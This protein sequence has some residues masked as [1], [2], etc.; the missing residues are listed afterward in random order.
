MCS[1]AGVRGPDAPSPPAR[2]RAARRRVGRDPG[3]RA[4]T[5]HPEGAEDPCS[6]ARLL[7]CS[8]AREARLSRQRRRLVASGAGRF[9]E[10]VAHRRRARPDT[11]SGE[12]LSL[13]RAATSPLT[14]P[15]SPP[16]PGPSRDAPDD[17][18]RHQRSGHL[19]DGEVL[20]AVRGLD[21]VEDRD[22]EVV[23]RDS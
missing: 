8:P 21:L 19:A 12:V 13:T 2:A 10:A 6:L 4:R 22:G 1:G 20:F 9:E 17:G 15:V 3:G 14:V 16:V 7:A 5:A 18:T 11:H 23:G